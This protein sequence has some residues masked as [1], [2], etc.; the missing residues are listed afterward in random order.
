MA[1]LHKEREIAE[2]DDLAKPAGPCEAEILGKNEA[3]KSHVK[4]EEKEKLEEKLPKLSA[5][6]FRVYNSMAEH[7]EYFVS[8]LFT[9]STGGSSGGRADRNSTIISDNR[10]RCCITHA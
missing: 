5:A 8:F 6:D 7:M 2:I 4:E 3:L 10:G 1:D 9:P